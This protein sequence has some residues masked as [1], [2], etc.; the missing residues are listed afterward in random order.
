MSEKKHRLCGAK[1]A[2]FR[3]CLMI[4]KRSEM[5]TP[6]IKYEH[7]HFKKSDEDDAIAYAEQYS[8][9]H[10]GYVVRLR[11]RIWCKEL[12]KVMWGTIISFYNGRIFSN[13]LI[14]K[15]KGYW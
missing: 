1:C 6:H 11:N 13:S 8:K 2:Q 4:F 15:T 7:I 10:K 9:E 5:G 14:Y 3:Y 12:N